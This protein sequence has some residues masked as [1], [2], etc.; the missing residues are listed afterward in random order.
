MY[1]AVSRTWQLSCYQ[2]QQV[3]QWCNQ[4]ETKNVV[5]FLLGIGLL[6]NGKENPTPQKYIQTSKQV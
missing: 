6:K 2:M 1:E 3:N 5:F 4:Q